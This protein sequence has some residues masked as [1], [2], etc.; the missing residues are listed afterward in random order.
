MNFRSAKSGLRWAA[1]AMVVLLAVSCLEA[2]PSGPTLHFDYGRGQPLDNPL[3]SF[4]YF[5]PLIAP[6]QVSVL[7]NAGNTQVARVNAVRRR[8]NGS[9]FHAVFDFDFDGDG[10]QRTVFDHA[11]T[12]RRR[13]KEWL[14]GKPLAHQIADI[15]VHGAGSGTV[16]ID[17]MLTNGAVTITE[18]R[19]RFNSRGHPSP[20]SVSL[21]D[22]ILR[23]GEIHRQNQ[24]VARVNTLTFRQ[25]LPPK[26]EVTLASVKKKDAANSLWQNLVGGVKGLTANLLL[27]PLTITADGQQ[28]MM[29]F[30]MALAMQKPAFTFPLATRLIDGT[31][32]AQADHGERTR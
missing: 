16:E 4:M 10:L 21:E 19:L 15:A 1:S 13:E 28:T 20:V 5:V 32:T 22:L 6:E 3:S 12:F 8:T 31:V 17:G 14:A 18:M 26:M 9:E 11:A 23:D 2:K 24:M 29:D 7:T 30:G 27:P 25:K